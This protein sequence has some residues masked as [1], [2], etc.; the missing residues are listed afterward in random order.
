MKQK[1]VLRCNFIVLLRP[2][3]SAN[4]LL[5]LLLAIERQRKGSSL[6]SPKVG[7]VEW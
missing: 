6:S 2:L 5:S 3:P 4:L 7:R 1:N